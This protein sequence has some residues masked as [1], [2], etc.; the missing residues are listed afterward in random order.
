MA[1]RSE[2]IDPT[3]ERIKQIVC[4]GCFCLVW[5]EKGSQC[6]SYTRC[7]QCIDRL[8]GLF[9]KRLDIR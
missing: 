6:D 4:R 2:Y 3:D 8:K 5:I 7:T 1:I 9:S